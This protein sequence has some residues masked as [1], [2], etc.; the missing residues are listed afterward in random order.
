VCFLLV[1]DP[2]IS[3]SA[4]SDEFEGDEDLAPFLEVAKNKLHV[5]YKTH[6]ANKTAPRPLPSNTSSQR[7]STLDRSPQK[8]FT[9]R[10]QRPRAP[11]D[12]LLEFWKLPQEDFDTCNPIRWWLG[13]RSSFPNLYRLACDVLSIPGGVSFYYYYYSSS[14]SSASAVAVERVFSGG[15][16]TISLRRASLKA[17]TIRTLMLVKKK[18]HLERE[19]ANRAL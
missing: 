13:R 10:F 18:L 2:R 17:E 4:L 12:E 11:I 8:N 16:D 15:R 6:Y 7:A 14:S 1:L 5:Y 3:Y 9:A 19:H